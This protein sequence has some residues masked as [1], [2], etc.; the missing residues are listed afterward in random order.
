L[1]RVGTKTN[2]GAIGRKGGLIV[3]GRVV[4]EAFDACAVGMNAVQIGRAAAFRRKDD[5]VALGCQEGL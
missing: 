1:A 3:K 2:P 4:G 5:P